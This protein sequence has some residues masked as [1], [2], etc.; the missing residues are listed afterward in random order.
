MYFFMV[1]TKGEMSKFPVDSNTP[2]PLTELL[3]PKFLHTDA[4]IYNYVEHHT[5]QES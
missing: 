1:V 5:I 2:I 4:K 3:Y